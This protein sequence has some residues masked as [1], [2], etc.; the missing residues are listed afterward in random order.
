MMGFFNNPIINILMQFNPDENINKNIYHKTNNSIKCNNNLSVISEQLNFL[1]L[2][3][4]G[5]V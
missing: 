2:E 3:I 1:W 5:N 4:N